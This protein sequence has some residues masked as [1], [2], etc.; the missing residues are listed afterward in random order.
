M[1][2]REYLEH[3]RD[4]YQLGE[5][6]FCAAP[7]GQGKT[8]YVGGIARTRRFALAFDQKGGDKT[9]ADLG[10]DRVTERNWP[11][12]RK[13]RA[14]M[15]DGKPYR[16]IL[17][18]VKRGPGA[19]E[20]RAAFHRGVLDTILEEGKWTAIIPDLAVLANKEMGNAWTKLVRLSILLRDYEGTLIVDAQRNARIPPEM[21]DMSTYLALGYTMDRDEVG[22][23]ARQVGYPPQ[24]L[25][26]AVSALKDLPYGWLIFSRN[27]REDVI[28]TRPEKL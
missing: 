13:E 5:H 16:R 4:H 3:V 28:L 19:I 24:V 11:P 23:L 9:L 17:G 15:E 27:P 8:T 12:T 22:D 1:P 7:T 21:A 25:R 10:W 20:Q 14:D 18:S 6:I 26:G 2:W